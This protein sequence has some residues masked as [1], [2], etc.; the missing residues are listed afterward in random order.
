MLE[1][2]L[3]YNRP[4]EFENFVWEINEIKYFINKYRQIDCDNEADYYYDFIILEFADINGDKLFSI[5]KYN[6]ENRMSFLC[7][8]YL[9][10]SE[11]LPN[12]LKK[13][14]IKYQINNFYYLD[15]DRGYQRIE[16]D[17]I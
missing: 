16:Q 8:P 7:N 9:I 14:K 11:A 3:V 5:R 15:I 13:L 4:F 6:D 12:I 17:S 1:K 2:N 10:V